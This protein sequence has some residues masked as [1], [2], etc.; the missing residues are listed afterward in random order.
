M[1]IAGKR[2]PRGTR[3][4]PGRSPTTP[5]NAAGVRKL[6]PRSLPVASQTDPLASAAAYPP[7][8]PPTLI[9]RS[10]GLRVAPK[11]GLNVLPLAHS[12]T[13]DLAIGIAPLLSSCRTVE[14][15][16]AATLWAKID[17]P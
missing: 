12:G 5:L 13:L 16:A 11:T 15:D 4:G 3:P 14:F 9:R 6:P 7:E 2:V 10:H 1:S 17:E 8:E